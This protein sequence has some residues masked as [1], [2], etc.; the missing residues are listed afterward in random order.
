MEEGVDRL[1]KG[2]VSPLGQSSRV[3]GVSKAS[4]YERHRWRKV[5]R[6]LRSRG[7]GPRLTNEL[8]GFARKLHMQ[9]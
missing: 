7:H 1:P 6:W 4:S 5:F 3:E 9:Q 8:T 2:G